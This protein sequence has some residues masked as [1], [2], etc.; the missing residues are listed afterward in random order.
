MY[1]LSKIIPVPM[2]SCYE[3]NRNDGMGYQPECA[4]WWQWR[5]RVWKHKINGNLV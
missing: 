3:S 1:K 4:S 2:N 5:G